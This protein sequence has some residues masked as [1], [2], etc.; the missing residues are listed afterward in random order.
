MSF[1]FPSFSPWFPAF[2][3]R[4]PTLSFWFPAFPPWFVAPWCS[5]Y[6][7]CTNSFNKAWAQVLRRFKSCTRC[8]RDSRWWGSL[9]MVPARNKAK[10]LPL[11]NQTTKKFII[12]IIIMPLILFPD[13][14]FR[15]LQ[16]AFPYNVFFC[17]ANVIGITT[18]TRK[19]IKKNKLHKTA[20]S[21]L[22]LL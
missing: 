2:P 9:T 17:F 16:I 6:H 20:V 14:P 12:I 18:G 1:L 10:R 13:Y 21:S 5:G 11:V 19:I 7:Y 22:V 3:P 15:L 8:V 4:L